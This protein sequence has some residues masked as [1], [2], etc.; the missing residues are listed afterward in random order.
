[1]HSPLDLG[2]LLRIPGTETYS[3]PRT[4]RYRRWA[5]SDRLR[6]DIL[7]QPYSEELRRAPRVIITGL[8]LAASDGECIGLLACPDPEAAPWSPGK[9]KKLTSSQIYLWPRLF[10][11]RCA[12]LCNG[13]QL[14]LSRHRYAEELRALCISKTMRHH[15]GLL[16]IALRWLRHLSLEP[17]DAETAFDTASTLLSATARSTEL[18]MAQDAL[19]Q[20]RIEIL[21]SSG[22]L[23]GQSCSGMNKS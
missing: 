6:A 4:T 16:E 22:G 10:A 11:I 8:H 18:P 13:D 1:M 14:D 15:D 12:M 9:P 2:A 5:E 7:H 20:L 3:G 19:Q 17:I 21:D 23:P